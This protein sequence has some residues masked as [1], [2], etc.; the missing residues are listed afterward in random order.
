MMTKL[1]T[2]ALETTYNKKPNEELIFHLD[3]YTQY[4]SIYIH[5]T[6]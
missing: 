2:K 3:L 5:Y 6:S 1:I 4:T